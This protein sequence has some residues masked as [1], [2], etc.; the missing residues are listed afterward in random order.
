MPDTPELTQPTLHDLLDELDRS[1]AHSDHLVVGLTDDQIRW[2]PTADSSAIGWHLGHQAAVAHYLLRNL[3]VAEPLIDPDIDALMD[4]AT[5]EPLRGELPTLKRLSEYRSVVAQR[6]HDHVVRIHNADVDAPHQLRIIAT[7]LLVAVVN[8][9]YQHAKWIGEVRTNT[10]D[11]D[12][13]PLPA[14]PW[15]TTVDGY[16][17]VAQH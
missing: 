10:F 7:T 1:N 13:P 5:P 9:N 6:I 8:H 17:I 12:A 16:K 14:S 2:R 15:L 11:L 3:V 4:S